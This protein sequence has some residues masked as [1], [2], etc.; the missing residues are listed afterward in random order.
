MV[1]RFLIIIIQIFLVVVRPFIATDE[2]MF[3]FWSAG[4]ASSLFSMQT[5][6]TIGT[7]NE[8]FGRIVSAGLG[9]ALD[10]S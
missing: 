10:H 5:L 7:L 6:I 1:M 2:S 9:H 4:F 3:Y 8:N